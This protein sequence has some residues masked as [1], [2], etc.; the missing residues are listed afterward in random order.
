M[1]LKKQT[2]KTIGA[3][4]TEVVLII[5]A[6]MFLLPIVWMF[7]Q[8]LKTPEQL[9]DF[10]KLFTF[11]ASFRAYEQG[12]DNGRFLTY[13]FNSVK[14]AVLCVTGT[15]FSCSLAGFAF[16][17]FQVKGKGILFMVVLS[18]MMVPTT[19]TLIPMYIFYSKLHWLNTIT[20]LVLPAFFGASTIIF[21]CCDSFLRGFPMSWQNLRSW[22]AQTGLPFLAVFIFLMQSRRFWLLRSTSWFSAGTIIW[23][24]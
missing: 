23:D 8:S 11:P 10:K 5:L 9:A 2:K 22:T 16:A 14:I 15:L 12:W 24:R 20:P 13:I 6:A 4:I 1:K 3:V 18:T 19:V 21:S 17:K 7:A